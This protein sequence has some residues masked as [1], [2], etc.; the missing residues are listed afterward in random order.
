MSKTPA[1]RRW[2]VEALEKLKQAWLEPNARPLIAACP[3]AGKT[4]MAATAVHDLLTAQ[5]CDVVLVVCPTVNIKSQWREQF[6]AFG[7]DAVDEATNEAFRSRRASGSHLTGGRTVICLTYNQVAMDS[8]LFVAIAHRHK[9]LV[10]GDEIHHA[11]DSAAFGSSIADLAHQAKYTLALSGTPFNSSGGALAMCE[12]EEQINDDGRL[13]RKALPIYTYSYGKAI[14]DHACR[15]VEFV[16]VMGKAYSTYR[17]LSDD[18]LFE[19]LIDLA[20]QNKTDSL[21]AILST[22]GEFMREMV[23]DSLKALA[24]IKRNDKRAGMLVVAR[25]TKH[26]NA[27]CQ[28]IEKQC[29]ENSEWAM[30]TC[31]EI[32]NDTPKAHDRIKQLSYDNTDVVITVR[33]I[34]EGVD[35]KRLRVGMYATDY[36][37]R[38]FFV[39]FI[40]RF[41]RWEDRLKGQMQHA[42][43]IIPGHVELL[44]FAREIEAMIDEALIPGEGDGD[45]VDPSPKTEWLYSESEKTADGLIYR[46]KEENERALAEAFFQKYPSLRGSIPE[47]LAAQGARDGNMNGFG[48]ETGSK[49]ERNLRKQN[50]DL[51]RAVVRVLRENGLTDDAIYA[52]VQSAA[53]KAAGI[54]NIDGL[55][56]DEALRKRKEFLFNWLRAIHKGEPH[57]Y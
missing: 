34:S 50:E 6:S 17:S 44:R 43:V 30:Y 12:S 11:D 56:T 38:M 4:L 48:H 57:A 39:Q 26:G 14:T 25:D 8:A 40:G 20:K 53:N 22:D 21:G 55:T 19:K 27:L 46:G 9:T 29:K 35:V 15:A 10:I 7:I 33:M 49:E 47:S 31:C 32:Y 52:K 18:S 45:P 24:D 37:T 51:M 42:R 2:Q 41:C 1:L 36:L 54:N 23:V 16:K 13:I 5:S 28:M 3:G